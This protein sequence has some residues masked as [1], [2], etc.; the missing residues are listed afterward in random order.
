MQKRGLG[1]LN[2]KAQ[3]FNWSTVLGILFGGAGLVIL[4]LILFGVWTPWGTAT[5]SF[6]PEELGFIGV[7]VVM[8]LLLVIGYRLVVASV[9]ARTDFDVFVIL[10]VLFL[11]IAQIMVNIGMN[12][13]I[14]PVTGLSLPFMSYGGSFLL[15]N[16]LMIGIV[17]SIIIHSQRIEG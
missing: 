10:G 4:L 6:I 11:F 13:G 15:L 8:I 3:G 2:K 5:S 7:S 1:N 16:L 9:R 12:I 14:M 17:E